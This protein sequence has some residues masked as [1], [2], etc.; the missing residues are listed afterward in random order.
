MY[1]R[2]EVR[3]Q[4]CERPFIHNMFEHFFHIVVPKS[5][6]FFELEIISS[7]FAGRF[8]MFLVLNFLW[9]EKK[10]GEK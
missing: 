4:Y 5:K 9:F 8:R 10:R 3:Y 6:G 1:R 2:G 7:I